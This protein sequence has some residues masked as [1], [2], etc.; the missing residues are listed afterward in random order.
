[1][2]DAHGKK[3][4]KSA[5]N[6]VDP[7]E[8]VDQYGA[9][10]LRF[11]LVT[12]NSPGNDIRFSAERVEAN[13]NFCNKIWNAARFV[14]MNV[15]FENPELPE[16]LELEDR[17]ILS[18]FNTLAREI[19]ANIDA[20][21]L[22]VAASNLYDF[23][24]DSY[25]DWYIELTKSRLNDRENP[26]ARENAGRV[27]AYVLSNTLKLLHPFM[28]FITEEIWQ[29]LPH[30]GDSIMVSPWPQFDPTL[31][32][33]EDERN[34][35]TIMAAIRAIRN[36]RA[37]MNVPP[38]RRARLTI[39]TSR[40]GLFADGEGYIR[41]LASASELVIGTSAPENTDGEVV[42]IT[43]AATM[44]LPM[45]ELVDIQAELARLAKERANA[46]QDLARTEGK[47]ANAG[48][49]AK[50]PANVVEQER[51]KAARLRELI[52]KIDESVKAFE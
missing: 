12:G 25:C 20:Y 15:D 38:S 26:A 52:A 48:F 19:T 33:A 42:I 34:M 27:L 24:W 40:P 32:F 11:C 22:G 21:E 44:Y 7:L 2:R 31:D 9:D 16:K 1:V 4:S 43:D 36:R 5:G 37:E 28:P 17:W 50:A 23:I 8:V 45:R 13:R 18:K 46:E 14:L 51:R 41:R 30:T 47:L 35:E 29:A 10:A 6:G 49:T 39:A 3:M